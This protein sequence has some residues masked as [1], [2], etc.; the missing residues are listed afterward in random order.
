MTHVFKDQGRRVSYALIAT[1]TL[2][3]TMAP[4]FVPFLSTASAEQITN[5]KIQM[6]SATPS[7][8]NV[9]YALT[10]TPSTTGARSVIV[11]FCS[12]SPMIGTAC[13]TPTAM[14][15][16]GAAATGVAGWTVTSASG[17]H[18]VLGGTPAL[19]TAEVTFT[20]TG[21]ANPSTLG[22]FF[23]RITTYVQTPAT[24]YVS[25]TSV[26]TTLDQG[27]VAL[28]ISNE[29]NVSAAV[30][31]TLVFC[32]SGEEPT[33]GCAGTT[34]PNVALGEGT[35]KALTT[36]D[37]STGSAYMQISSN[38]VSGVTVFMK[39]SNA[40]GGLSRNGG[41]TCEIAPMNNATVAAPLL[42][43]TALFGVQ[44]SGHTAAS[45]AGTPTGVITPTAPYNGTTTNYG[46]NN[47]SG[48]T[49]SSTF[50][51]PIADTAAAPSSNLNSMLTFAASAAGTTP[52]GVYSAKL[53]LVAVGTY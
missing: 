50:G 1:L 41:T 39:S 5:R 35:P 52:A 20:I 16:T 51:S 34:T 49:V 10:F 42:A 36:G 11:D 6:S 25:P 22:T 8:A 23:A 38:A 14:N 24:A 21:I 26:G 33:Q 7:A 9:S 15:T 29:I 43:G 19:T 13:T 4:S 47:A 44:V 40:C 28:S 45:G 17:G 31:E 18:I 3:F 27:S 32:V 46:M 2:L 12:T 30:M 37:V 48:A 53:T